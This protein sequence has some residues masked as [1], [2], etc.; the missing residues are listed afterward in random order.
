MALE[1]ITLLLLLSPR[2]R[3]S[4]DWL[5]VMLLTLVLTGLPS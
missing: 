3:L 1:I 5:L 4:W 2:A